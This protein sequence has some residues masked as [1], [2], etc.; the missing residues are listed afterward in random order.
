MIIEKYLTERKPTKKDFDVKDGAM[1]LASEIEMLV[2]KLLKE[3]YG[4]EGFKNMEKD[5]VAKMINLAVKN[6][7]S[8]IIIS[9]I[10]P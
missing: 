1:A 10:L 8:K 7:K 2:V 4:K 6:I 3:W 5:E 9:E